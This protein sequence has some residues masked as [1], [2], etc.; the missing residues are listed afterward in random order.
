M[1]TPQSARDLLDH[2]EAFAELSLLF[3]EA[4]QLLRRAAAQGVET[5]RGETGIEAQRVLE[6]LGDWLARAE[7]AS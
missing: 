5:F 6:R 7:T 3:A 1:P 2:A 4:S